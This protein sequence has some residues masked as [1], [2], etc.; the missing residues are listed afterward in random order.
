MCLISH[1]YFF[2][3]VQDQLKVVL[4]N[5]KFFDPHRT[6]SLLS[7]LR[8]FNTPP[9][10]VGIKAVVGSEYYGIRKD[11]PLRAQNPLPYGD[12]DKI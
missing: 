2:A 4:E 1:N 10:A 5:M 3:T 12:G 9:L 11:F 8:F 6:L 7:L